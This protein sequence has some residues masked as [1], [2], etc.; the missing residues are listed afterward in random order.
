MSSRTRNAA[1]NEL[2]LAFSKLTIASPRASVYGVFP[3]E[4]WMLIRDQLSEKDDRSS[5][6]NL[7]LCNK[8]FKD[9]MQAALYSEFITDSD[10]A[11][12]PR[13]VAAFLATVS[14]S[15]R[16][17]SFVKF[18]WVGTVLADDDPF[19]YSAA[20]SFLE[21]MD[22]GVAL[23]LLASISGSEIRTS[24]IP[25]MMM[26]M[27]PSL[28]PNLEEHT[29]HKGFLPSTTSTMGRD[30]V[31]LWASQ[32]PT[33]RL[34]LLKHLNISYKKPMVH[35]ALFHLVD[36]FSTAAPNIDTLRFRIFRADWNGEKVYQCL[37]QGSQLN[38]SFKKIRDFQFET[39]DESEVMEAFHFLWRC[40][41]LESI[42]MFA[43]D[44]DGHEDWTLYLDSIMYLR[45]D[46]QHM[47]E[48]I[49]NPVLGPAVRLPPAIPPNRCIYTSFYTLRY[50]EHLKHV[51]VNEP[52]III[53]SRM[54][55]DDTTK[56]LVDFL[57]ESVVT[58]RI[59]DA[60][61]ALYW[62]I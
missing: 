36:Q 33:N 35:F 43:A 50:Q 32:S 34:P 62:G 42:E 55:E 21:R 9:M 4:L 20:E 25:S 8:A 31:R 7:T 14:L 18:V 24:Q 39:D 5:L 61:T 11:R 56:T 12:H 6:A 51:T 58:L 22:D 46:F 27:L 40:R 15:P 44:M 47:S 59:K 23:L 37:E 10:E 60:T 29:L 2:T 1:I 30:Y 54:R 38:E 17:A 13:S 53:S 3:A 48:L 41:E 57:P 52:L 16:L 45:I 28:L 19:V 26:E 49:L